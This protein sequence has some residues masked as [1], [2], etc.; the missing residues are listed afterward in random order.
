MIKIHYFFYK[1]YLKV[2]F[3]DITFIVT[4]EIYVCTTVIPPTSSEEVRCTVQSTSVVS[5]SCGEYHKVVGTEYVAFYPIRRPR[6]P[7]EVHC[8]IGRRVTNRK[9]LQF[10]SK[11]LTFKRL[12]VNIQAHILHKMYPIL[13]LLCNISPKTMDFW[14]NFFL[15][16]N[17]C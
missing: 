6:I 11:W 16:F 8:I 2:Y 13:K 10:H 5:I 17:I 14:G 9:R 7:R 1:V 3:S 15:L 12:N 4:I